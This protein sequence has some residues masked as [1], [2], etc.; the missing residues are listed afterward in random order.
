[1]T[2]GCLARFECPTQQRQIRCSTLMSIRVEHR[3]QLAPSRSADTLHAHVYPPCTACRNNEST[4]LKC[5][6]ADY[7]IISGIK[8]TPPRYDTR[9]GHVKDYCAPRSITTNRRRVELLYTPPYIYQTM[10][11]SITAIKSLNTAAVRTYPRA[12]PASTPVYRDSCTAIYVRV[13]QRA[14][15]DCY[16]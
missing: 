14:T 9:T 10:R 16:R 6:A 8:N 2:Q 12:M 7:H 3:R 11:C 5:H 15:L 1:M 13:S 4:T